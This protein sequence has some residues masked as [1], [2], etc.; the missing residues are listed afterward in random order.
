[1]S[2]LKA[3][4]IEELL[5]LSTNGALFPALSFLVLDGC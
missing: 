5:V 3:L 1:M 4:R 2:M